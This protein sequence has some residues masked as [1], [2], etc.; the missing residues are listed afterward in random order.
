DM[1]SS[2]KEEAPSGT[3]LASEMDRTIFPAKA[4]IKETI[5]ERMCRYYSY[6][7]P[8]L[9]VIFNGKKFKSKDGLLD[10]LRE[11][12][13]GEALYA[14]IHLK[15]DDIEVAFTHTVDSGEEYYTFVNGQNTTQGGTHL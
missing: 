5:V 9:T 14:P 7:N 12:M 10:L 15:G 6:L 11:E 1:K 3:R 4:E 2:R 13:E 8:G